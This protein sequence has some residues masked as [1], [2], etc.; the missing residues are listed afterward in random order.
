MFAAFS[1]PAPPAPLV[2]RLAHGLLAL[3][4]AACALPAA[5]AIPATERDVLIALYEQTQ[6]DGWYLGGSAVSWKDGGAF[7]AAGTEC[8]WYGIFC[9][10]AQD[11]V[12][13][14]L[15]SG[16]HL[17][18]T[19][20]D[21]LNQLTALETF[22]VTYNRLTGPIPSLTGLTALLRFSIDNNQLTGP[23]PSI[24]G[25]TALESFHVGQ[26]QLTGPVPTAPANLMA[27]G[28]SLC[29]NHLTPSPDPDWDTATGDTPWSRDCTAA[30]AY[31]VSANPAGAFTAVT[32]S[33]GDT[34][35]ISFNPPPAGQQLNQVA[36]TCGLTADEDPVL[37]PG[38]L[39]QFT[40]R[41][42]IADCE[43]TL[44]YVPAGATAPH[45]PTDLV[46]TPGD[47]QATLS[48]NPP[49]NDG[50]S[51]ITGYTAS[52]YPY[53]SG[54][55]VIVSGAASPIVVGGLT[56]GM[57]YDCVVVATNAVG[58]SLPTPE[59]QVTPQAQAAPPAQVTPVPTL[60][61][62]SLLLLGLLAAGLGV[63]GLRRRG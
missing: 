3:L 27:H 10:S 8:D 16:R 49:A 30:P 39:D 4:L 41:P 21:T 14:I 38:P 40:T 5:A 33:A 50:G 11:R 28:S 13:R 47:G 1:R 29:P 25:L 26:N 24:D 19:L 20:P 43:L 48:F 34:P 18:G 46:A 42:L 31:T 55:P 56:N 35:T 12:V 2:T 9:N 23:I 17:T 52:C 61:E 59:E 36:S 62:W 15:L 45:A 22:H 60:G 7:R 53:D 51:P 32:A 63:R 6:G 58:D 37:T 54:P 44:T 57:N